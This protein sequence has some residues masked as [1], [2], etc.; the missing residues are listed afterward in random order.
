MLELR[1]AVQIYLLSV[2][3]SQFLVCPLLLLVSSVAG[4]GSSVLGVSQ[5][6]R[7]SRR[8]VPLQGLA[9]LL[10]LGLTVSACVS[11][12]LLLGAGTADLDLVAK[13][14]SLVLKEGEVWEVV[15]ATYQCCGLTGQAGHEQWVGVVGDSERYPDS[16]C[17]LK[18][19]GCGRHAWQTLQSDFANTFSERIFSTGCITVIRYTSHLTSKAIK[20]LTLTGKS[21]RR[22]SL[23]CLSVSAF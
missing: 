2:L 8:L 11:T 12:A 9:S 13:N 15:Q 16:C 18:Y 3:S 1:A 23:L 10:G 19:P 17:T 22:Q 21:W 20:P 14:G 6:G 4:L 5:L 7:R